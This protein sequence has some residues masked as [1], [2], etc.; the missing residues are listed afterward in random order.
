MNEG[1]KIDTEAISKA[2]SEAWYEPGVIYEKNY[3]R[4]DQKFIC[5]VLEQREV[6]GDMYS[7]L[8]PVPILEKRQ[9]P[10]GVEQRERILEIMYLFKSKSHSEAFDYVKANYNKIDDKVKA[11]VKRVI[12]Q[13]SS[14]I[15]TPFNGRR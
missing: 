13:G 6:K 4:K 12:Q 2:V 11:E 1:V 10:Q 7:T 14:K 5:H 9:T 8:V 15:V 3:L